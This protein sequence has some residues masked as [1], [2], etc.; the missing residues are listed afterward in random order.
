[1]ILF[2]E[3]KNC[4]TKLSEEELGSLQNVFV[5]MLIFQH[6]TFMCIGKD[7]VTLILVL[8]STKCSPYFK[9]FGIGFEKF[10]KIYQNVS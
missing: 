10:G 9:K 7:I 2:S 3:A 1:M 4:V 8:K 6:K 5:E